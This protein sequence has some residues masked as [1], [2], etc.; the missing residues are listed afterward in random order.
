MPALAHLSDV[1]GNL[2]VIVLIAI[3]LK[4]N[5]GRSEQSPACTGGYEA[6]Y[7]DQLV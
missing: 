1:I 5:T 4:I 6:P 2:Y 7:T 3:M